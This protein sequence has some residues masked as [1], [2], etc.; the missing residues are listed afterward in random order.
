MTYQLG[1]FIVSLLFL[2]IWFSGTRAVKL[3]FQKIIM[4]FKY[5]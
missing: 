2:L 5:N 4:K 1:Y 3:N